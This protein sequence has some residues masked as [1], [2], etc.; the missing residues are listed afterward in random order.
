[1]FEGVFVSLLYD[2]VHVIGVDFTVG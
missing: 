1:V 2:I